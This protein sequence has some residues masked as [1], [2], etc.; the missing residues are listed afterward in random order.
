MEPITLSMS[1]LSSMDETIRARAI[2]SFTPAGSASFSCPRETIHGRFIIWT[3]FWIM[4]RFLA[5]LSKND[6]SL[7]S[8]IVL[9]LGFCRVSAK[10]SNTS[11]RIRVCLGRLANIGVCEG[12]T[13]VRISSLLSLLLMVLY[14]VWFMS[15]FP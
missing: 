9:R 4:T 8:A 12:E 13:K 14:W 2:S 5:L 10:Y 7:P 1:V 11:L 3:R 15:I 6:T